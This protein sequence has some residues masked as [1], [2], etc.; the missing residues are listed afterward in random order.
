MATSFCFSN[1]SLNSLCLDVASSICF[2]HCCYGHLL[3]LLEQVTQLLVFGCGIF[4]LLLIRGCLLRHFRSIP[5]TKFLDESLFFLAAVLKR[6]HDAWV[7]GVI[8]HKLFEFVVVAGAFIL[9]PIIARVLGKVLD[10]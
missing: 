6:R 1:R 7:F 4:Y 3:L 2:L 10:R 8:L 5:L 9:L